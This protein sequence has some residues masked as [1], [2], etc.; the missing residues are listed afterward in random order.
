MRLK[1]NQTHPIYVNYV[2]YVANPALPATS[3]SSPVTDQ[4]DHIMGFMLLIRNAYVYVCW[5]CVGVRVHT[6]MRVSVC[7]QA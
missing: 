1:I 5:L 4:H 6:H 7:V 3:C 2:S